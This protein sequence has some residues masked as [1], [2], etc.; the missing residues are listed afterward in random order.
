[1]RKIYFASLIAAGLFLQSGNAQTV[2]SGNEKEITKPNG[3]CHVASAAQKGEAAFEK[4]AAGKSDEPAKSGNYSQLDPAS[5]Q[6]VKEIF[7]DLSKQNRISL[8]ESIRQFIAQN[9][10]HDRS[11]SDTLSVFREGAASH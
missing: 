3:Q 1:M 7:A 2:S 6:A 10:A 9:L 8:E 11:I 4:G 5:E